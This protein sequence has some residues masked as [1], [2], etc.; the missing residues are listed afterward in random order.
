MAIFLC[1]PGEAKG[2]LRKRMERSGHADERIVAVET[3]DKMTE[4]QFAVKV[5][6]VF[7]E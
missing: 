2:E 3:V 6:S 7:A 4:N 1:G 5:G